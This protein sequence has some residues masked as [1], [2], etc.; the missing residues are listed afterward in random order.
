LYICI[1][2]HQQAQ[3]TMNATTA[4]AQVELN[5]NQL[6]ILNAINA[7]GERRDY[8]ATRTYGIKCANQLLKMG[9]I[10]K[11]DSA[12]KYPGSKYDRMLVFFKATEAGAELLASKG[13]K[14]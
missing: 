1:V 2:F 7:D 11:F 8:I 3:Q 13:L 12:V 5:E 10:E 14:R 9:L 4:T 6:D